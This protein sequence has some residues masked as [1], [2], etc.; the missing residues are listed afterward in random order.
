MDLARE[1]VK[2]FVL[3]CRN[4]QFSFRNTDEQ[5]KKILCEKLPS[6]HKDVVDCRET[7]SKHS[8]YLQRISCRSSV[9]FFPWPVSG[10][11]HRPAFEALCRISMQRY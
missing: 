10:N 11:F 5:L 7:Y 8:R 3:P 6:G 1:N 9:Q 4:I 2:Q